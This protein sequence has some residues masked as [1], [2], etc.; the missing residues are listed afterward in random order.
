MLIKIKVIKIRRFFILLIRY[1]LVSIT[2]SDTAL[3]LI[4]FCQPNFS[5]FNRFALLPAGFIIVLPNLS[6]LPVL[7]S[8]GFSKSWAWASV[9]YA[10]TIKKLLRSV[11]DQLW[12][13]VI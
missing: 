8:L 7:I 9:R 10:F 2:S 1:F 5:K 12:P 4:P 6:V 13:S 11:S 3:A